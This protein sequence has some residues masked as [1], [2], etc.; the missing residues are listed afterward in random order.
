[1]IVKYWNSL[2]DFIELWL[3]KTLYQL[4][5]LKHRPRLI[6]H[7]TFIRED[8]FDNSLDMD[9]YAMMDMNKEDRKKYLNDLTR[10][11][12]IAHERDMEND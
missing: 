12:R 4:K 1:M 7:K 8:E 6:W 10:R 3:D 2:L 9:G 5:M 11:R